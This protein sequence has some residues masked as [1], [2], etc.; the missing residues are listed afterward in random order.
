MNR[1]YNV[2]AGHGKIRFSYRIMLLIDDSS[3][4]ARMMDTLRANSEINEWI[5]N[6]RGRWNFLYKIDDNMLYLDTL[7]IVDRFK[8]TF[9]GKESKHYIIK[10]M[11]SKNSNK[12]K[13]NR[14]E[15]K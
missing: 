1:I 12:R 11:R 10:S 2:D 9:K 6:S 7:Q 5:A 14:G 3:P 8:E 15:D 13:K 4:I